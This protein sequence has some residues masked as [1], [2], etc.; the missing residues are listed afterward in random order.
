MDTSAQN[1]HSAFCAEKYSPEGLNFVSSICVEKIEAI[2]CPST[3]VV[4]S[5]C[6]QVRVLSTKR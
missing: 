1:L 5:V 2:V 4:D 6:N 3:V